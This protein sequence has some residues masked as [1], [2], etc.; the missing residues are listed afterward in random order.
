MRSSVQSA[1]GFVALFGA[2][3][4]CSS[5]STTGNNGTVGGT[6]GQSFGDAQATGGRGNTG[7][8]LANIAGSHASTGGALANAGGAHTGGFGTV[9]TGGRLATGGA[10]NAGGQ[11][12]ISG[13][14]NLEGQVAA[15]FNCP[16]FTSQQAIAAACMQSDSGFP[17]TCQSTLDSLTTCLSQQPSSSF[18]C[19]A[20]N[21]GTIEVKDGVCTS[22]V[23]AVV[24]CALGGTGGGCTDLAP[25]CA[26]LTGTTQ[27]SCQQLI[28]DAVDSMCGLALSTYQQLGM[29]I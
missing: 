19:S 1:L 12:S 3:C 23:G 11:A 8:S 15:Q 29:C 7:G 4:A 17:A 16:G 13:L 22:Q 2:L 18:Q 6:A 21:D 25:C 24:D 14:C 20:D 9:A 27:S 26:Q 10:Q 28:T 5:S